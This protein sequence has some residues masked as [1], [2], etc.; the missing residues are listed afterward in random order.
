MDVVTFFMLLSAA[1]VILFIV[2]NVLKGFIKNRKM[3]QTL[4]IFLL[5]FYLTLF[6][7][8]FID[9]ALE[10]VYM[11]TTGKIIFVLLLLAL[12]RMIFTRN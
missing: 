11:E 2:L 1:D 8:Y 6:A 7:V 5:E 10:D 4:P 12:E 9:L 3:E